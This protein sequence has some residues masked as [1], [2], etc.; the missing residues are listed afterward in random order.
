VIARRKSLR[1]Q[2]RRAARDLEY[3]QAAEKGHVSYEARGAPEGVPRGQWL[4]GAGT[5]G[6]QVLTNAAR[7]GPKPSPRDL[8]PGHHI[9][10]RW[11]S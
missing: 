3:V 8:R 6:V 2:L 10:E 4:A 7:G 5:L 1:S 11:S 9:P